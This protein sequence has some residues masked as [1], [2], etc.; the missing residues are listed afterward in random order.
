MPEESNLI[1][2]TL[3]GLQV[4]GASQTLRRNMESCLNPTLNARES[5]IQSEHHAD[6]P[7]REHD[8]I[9]PIFFLLF[10]LFRIV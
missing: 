2:T 10:L 8:V 9:S 1:D 3:R 7:P 5:D 6:K 4:S